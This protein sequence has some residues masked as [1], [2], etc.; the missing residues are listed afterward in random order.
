MPRISRPISLTLDVERFLILDFNACVAIE[1]VTGVNALSTA[2]WRK[3]GPKHVRAALWAALLHENKPQTLEQVGALID[4]HLD[5][6]GAI[7]KALVLA[8]NEVLP[9]LP[10]KESTSAA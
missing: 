9:E 4:A 2:Y 10:K 8:W 6:W 3:L 5:K 7:L 1:E